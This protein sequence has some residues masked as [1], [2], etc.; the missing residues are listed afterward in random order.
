M[1]K[2][3]GCLKCLFIFFNVLFAII[4]CLLIYGVVQATVYSSQLST[5]GSPGLGW[6]WVFAIGVLAISILGIYAGFSE[7]ELALKIF[8][9]FMGVGMIIMLI[10][11][12]IIAVTRNNVKEALQNASSEIGHRLLEDEEGKQTLYGLQESAQCCGL[13]GPEDWHQNIPDSCECKSEGSGF[14]G[15]GG[16]RTRPQGAT[17]PSRIYSQGCG[18]IFF[19]AFDLVFKISMGIC[20]GFSITA[21]LGLLVSLFMIRQVRRHDGAGGNMAMKGY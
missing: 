3:N 4:G 20:F 13:G 19:L 5:I 8:A 15:T 17:G 11:G 10:F 12:I 16:C 21:L 9:G 2:I 18:Q 6:G 14:F 1:G 7:K